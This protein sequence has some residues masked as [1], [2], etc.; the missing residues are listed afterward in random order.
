MMLNNEKWFLSCSE[1]ME[2][3]VSYLVKTTRPYLLG[4]FFITLL[5]FN[6]SIL[7]A[8]V[9]FERT[10]GGVGQEEGFSVC[11]TED[12]GYLVAGS[13]ESYGAGWRDVYLVRTD[14]VGDTLWTRTYGGIWSDYAVFVQETSDGG[15]II[16]G[17]SNSR[18]WP[19]YDCYLIRIDANG[20]TLW[21]QLYG[22][23]DDEYAHAVQQTDDGGYIIAGYTYSYGAGAADAWLIKTD[24]EGD[25]LW[26]RTY[27]GQLTETAQ[28]VQQTTDGGFIVTGLTE[29][30]GAGERDAY[31]L[32]TDVH[33]NPLWVR[34]LGTSEFE[35]GHIVY[36]T[37]DGGYIILGGTT[38][39]DRAGDIALLKMNANGAIMW[40]RTYGG[41]GL[42]SGNA[43]DQTP[44]GGYIIAGSNFSY[45]TWTGDLYLLRTDALGDT[46]W[47][48]N[49]GGLETDYAWSVRQASDGG[50]I[51]SG[52]TN[53]YGAGDYD[54]YLVKVDSEGRFNGTQS[55][56]ARSSLEAREAVSSGQKPLNILGP[57]GIF[58][59]D[60]LEE[61]CSFLARAFP[62]YG[63]G[64]IREE[65]SNSCRNPSLDSVI[66]KD[67]RIE[68]IK[69][70]NH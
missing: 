52:G 26:T 14:S 4:L 65:Q 9:T 55:S 53:S 49:I 36:E 59:C 54:I 8:L 43:M 20:N 39:Y 37:S 1:I 18:D 61:S 51:I 44:D 10:Y 33:G 67:K 63:R 21:T 7:S 47:T 31:L 35:G 6:F 27:G 66:G 32:K 62:F 58:G 19:K 45:H 24:I 2:G 56:R 22:G 48:R 12:E 42:Q 29:S 17:S 16:A 5:F 30:F 34:V 11:Q 60:I 13:T 15:F 68:W 50:F 23:A 25:T 38:F 64:Y 41:G 70:T 3:V 69:R 46:L 40:L 28:S 57:P